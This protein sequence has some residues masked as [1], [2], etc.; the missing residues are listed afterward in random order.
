MT[1]F[2]SLLEWMS[3][4]DKDNRFMAAS[5]I[6]SKMTASASALDSRQQ[7]RFTAA[8]LKQLSDSSIE[9]QGNAAKCIA[10]IVSLL[11]PSES[12]DVITNVSNKIVEGA[13]E[14]RDVYAT[15]FKG[16]L[17]VIPD[18]ISKHVWDQILPRTFFC[19]T[20][21]APRDPGN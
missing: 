10:R 9:V 18:S 13:V 15:C 2:E 12:M 11:Q 5:D 20:P 4:Y 8:L 17:K 7:S 1:S 6:V 3:H 19:W 16:L 14:L 21:K